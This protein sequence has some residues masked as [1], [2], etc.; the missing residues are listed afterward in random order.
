[1]TDPRT[2]LEA[3]GQLPDGEID[4]AEAAL[5]L[6]R[7]DAPEADWQAARGEF[8]ALA[9]EAVA[10]ADEI[11]VDDLAGQ[12]V[13]LQ[14]LVAEGHGYRG[15]T[16][17]YDD[18]ANANLIRVAARRRGLPVALGVVWLHTAQ[19]AGW[20]AHGVD[21]PGHFLI[22]LACP[23][24]QAVLD[25]FDG[26]RSLDAAALRTLLRAFEGPRAELRADLLR[27][28]GSRAVLLR[29]QN[30][31][32][33]RRLRAGDL[34]GALACTE[35]MLRIAPEEVSQWREAG[36]M[37]SRLERLATA[38]HC[39]ERFLALAPAGETAA[40]VRAAMDEL[41]SRLN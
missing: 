30:N 23:G 16:D 31:I 15:D 32:K 26:G 9:R 7:V 40:R 33:L 8:S 24:Q 25:V 37:N 27:P 17:S 10:L 29:L 20:S 4:I 35:D 34:A 19:A 5:Q 18:P 2:A 39:Y 21:F 13:A 1:M 41:R 3:I 14:Q 36:L 11:G 6:A 22:A 38:L 28:M 12:A